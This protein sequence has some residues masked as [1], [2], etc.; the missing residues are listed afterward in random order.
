MEVTRALRSNA[1]GDSAWRREKASSWRIRCRAAQAGF[2]RQVDQFLGGGPQLGQIMQQV[3]IADHDRQQVIEVVRQAAGQ[4]ADRLHALRMLELPARRLAIRHVLDDADGTAHALVAV[5]ERRAGHPQL[6]RGVLGRLLVKLDVGQHLAFEQAAHHVA[7]LGA[8]DLDQRRE[9]PADDVGRRQPE[10]PL[11]I[12]V[13]DDHAARRI[14]AEDGDRRRLDH[15]IERLVGVAQRRHHV[16]ALGDVADDGGEDGAPFLDHLRDIGFGRELDAAPAPPAEFVG[17]PDLH[18]RVP[19]RAE[20]PDLL[21]DRRDES[22]RQQNLGTLADR[23]VGTVAEQAL[24][25]LVEH[26]DM[27]RLVHRDDG[28]GRDREDLA[29]ARLHHALPGFG[30]G[31]LAPHRGVAHL[32]LDRRREALEVPF[33]DVV[34]GAG[35]HGA[36][37]H[38]LADRAGHENERHVGVPVAHDL[39]RLDAGEAR[40]MKVAQDDVPGL[41]VQRGLEARFGVGPLGADVVALAPQ[42]ADQQLRIVRGI[43]DDQGFE[44]RCHVSAAALR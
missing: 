11:G 10:D 22:G 2:Q 4:L 43:V 28:I 24:G 35:L 20:L 1:F 30:G 23:F 26:G 6:E 21:P 42:L 14:E 44:R 37:R 32:P 25:G 18:R 29:I 19:G 40:H 7:E 27:Q 31:A 34:L 15:G 33:H 8:G 39:E 17:H 41:I 13:P 3:E 12:P 5:I 16:L 36:H 38:V 9:G